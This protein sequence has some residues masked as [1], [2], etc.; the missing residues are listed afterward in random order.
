MKR[1]LIGLALTALLAVSV[2][3]TA[4]LETI[5]SPE[6]TVSAGWNLLA[7]P[8]IPVDPDPVN[9]LSA[10]EIDSVLSRWDAAT[11][12]LVIYDMWAPEVFGNMLLGDGY[13]LETPVAGQI[14]YQGLTDNDD[15]DVWISL[16][17]AGWSLIGNPFSTPFPWEQAKVVDG[18]TTV[19]LYDATRTNG[20]MNSMGWWW[21]NETRSLREFGIA[22]DWT[23]NVNLLPW[24]G[25]WVESYVDKIALIL[26]SQS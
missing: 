3:A 13:W 10:F 6:G 14:S 7:L 21:D 8:G 2:P 18:N 23:E 25:Y 20:W 26:E 5:T 15:M 12:A 17:K 16:P 22:D 24:H 4:A 1:V 9:V 11:R 19:S